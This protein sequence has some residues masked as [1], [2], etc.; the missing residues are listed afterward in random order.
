MKAYKATELFQ[1]MAIVSLNIGNLTLEINILK[2]KL[3]MGEKKKG[4]LHEELDKKRNFQ[5]GYNHNVE[6]QKKNKAKAKLKN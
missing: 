4:K 2:N 1:A 3:V 5:K 6:I